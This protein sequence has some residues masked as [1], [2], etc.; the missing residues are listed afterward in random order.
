M[1]WPET[2]GYYISGR[3]PIFG[4]GKASETKMQNVHSNNDIEIVDEG[5]A[6]W[7]Y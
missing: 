1:K 5:E 4:A 3:Q 7:D 2:Y 6:D